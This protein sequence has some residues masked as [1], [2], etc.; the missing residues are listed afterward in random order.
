MSAARTPAPP[1]FHEINEDL[2]A[3]WCHTPWRATELE[4]DGRAYHGVFDVDPGADV[5]DRAPCPPILHG[6]V[7]AQL[8][9]YHALASMMFACTNRHHPVFAPFPRVAPAEAR[10]RTMVSSY[11]LALDRPVTERRV[12]L[13]LTFERVTDKWES[14]RMAFAVLGIEVAGGR[15]TAELEGC[16]DFRDGLG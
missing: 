5:S 1:T 11:R 14:H 15:H 4:Y 13:S 10:R 6:S 16:F 12:P 7:L 8:V 3:A 2:A 9:S